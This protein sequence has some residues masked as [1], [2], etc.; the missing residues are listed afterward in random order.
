MIYAGAQLTFLAISEGGEGGG[1]VEGGSKVPPILHC[2]I[3]SITEV[4]GN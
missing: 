4:G 3:L 1:G 2:L